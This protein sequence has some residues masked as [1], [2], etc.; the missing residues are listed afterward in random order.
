[1][2]II[3]NILY[4]NSFPIKPQKLSNLTPKQQQ[5]LPT[6]KCRWAT[7]TY[8]GKETTYITNIFKHSDLRIAYRTN[9]TIHSH[10]T[11]KNQNPDKFSLSGVYK[12]TCPD[13]K[14]AFVGQTGRNFTIRYNEHKHAFQSNS[15]SSRFAQHLSE[16]AHSCG[17]VNNTMQVL[18]YQNKGAHLNT[19]EQFYIHAEHASN[20][21]LNDSHTIFPNRIF[22]TLLKTYHP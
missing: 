2:N 3:H 20:N 4:N 18:H 5:I 21:H 17:T 7:F 12:L 15:H 10:L 8:V 19:I 16:H 9:N 6:P 11:H 14:K 22:D 13:C 1:V